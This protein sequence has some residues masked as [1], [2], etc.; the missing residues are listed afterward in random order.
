MPTGGYTDLALRIQELGYNN[1]FDLATGKVTGEYPKLEIDFA[2]S[3]PGRI[4]LQHYEDEFR[5]NK[6]LLPYTEQVKIDGVTKTIEHPSKLK[7]GDVV[8]YTHD[9]ETPS[10][11]IK[12]ICVLD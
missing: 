9:D 12:V 8:L 6:H 7:L 4:V 1:R 11:D 2:P 5:V 3:T 10:G